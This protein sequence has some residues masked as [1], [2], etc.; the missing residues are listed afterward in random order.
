MPLLM[1]KCPHTARPVSTGIEI[2]ALQLGSLPDVPM[3]V[4]CAACGMVH[5]WWKREAWLADYGGRPLTAAPAILRTSGRA[6]RL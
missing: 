2:E 6:V 4:S 5:T 1:I 3:S